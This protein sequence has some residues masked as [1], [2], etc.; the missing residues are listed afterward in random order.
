M[1][2]VRG[3]FFFHPS[4]LVHPVYVAKEMLPLWTSRLLW[5]PTYLVL[6]GCKRTFQK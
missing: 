5:P 1:C 4:N 3:G 2:G 6:K